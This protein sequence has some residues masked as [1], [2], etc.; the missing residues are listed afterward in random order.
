MKTIEW[1]LIKK[2]LSSDLTTSE[3]RMLEDWLNDAPENK[4]LYENSRKFYTI[5]KGQA[6]HL[7]QKELNQSWKNFVAQ[8]RTRRLS[9]IK[10]SSIAASVLLI[11][12]TG[13]FMIPSKRALPTIVSNN[14]NG[15]TFTIDGDKCYNLDEKN[16]LRVDKNQ[17]SELI[18]ER[19]AK[20]IM[21]KKRINDKTR[22]TLTSNQNDIY[23]MTLEDGT[24]V[25]LNK[26][27]S[28][29]F[30]ISFHKNYREVMVTGEVY[31]EVS[32]DP[33]KPFIVQ[34]EKLN[35][36]VLGTKFNVTE[37][38]TSLIEG[39]VE[40]ELKSTK[41]KLKLIPGTEGII[42]SDKQSL[43]VKTIDIE[44]TIAWTTN[45]MIIKDS[46]LEEIMNRI[47]KKYGVKIQFMEETLK[48]SRYTLYTNDDSTL[49][50]MLITLGKLND[51]TITLQ[52]GTIIIS[53]KE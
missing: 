46:T 15:V 2:S 1:K 43:V 22:A 40:L 19:S 35:I 9:I 44:S 11:F 51:I 21:E 4:K 30:P 53:K 36:R 25:W 17:I 26:S 45:R 29:N 23:K 37:S 38:T 39:S 42:D 48:E 41:Q 7:S 31:F 14:T 8:K 12:A 16:T 47:G 13:Y 33:S 50:E 27:S 32:H 10:Y 49:G 52:E 28:I 24:K 20:S 6:F 34:T 18:D 5:E 3:Q